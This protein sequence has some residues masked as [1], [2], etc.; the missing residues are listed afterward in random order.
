MLLAA[1]NLLW[2]PWTLALSIALWLATAVVGWMS[3][4]RSGYRRQIA[5]L[6]GI[7]LSVLA[8]VALLINQPEFLQIQKRQGKPTVAVLVDRSASMETADIP[9]GEENPSELVRRSAMA[10]PL[11]SEATWS[12]LRQRFDVALQPICSAQPGSGSNLCGPLENLVENSRDLVAIVLVSDGD[13]NEGSAPINAANRLRMANI[14][15]LS[16]PVGSPL[17]LP[18]VELKS[19]N[20]PAIG[21]V[22]K[23]LRIPFT[24][25]SSLP[26]DFVAAVTLTTST[27]E[28]VAADVHVE[29]NSQTEGALV[30]RPVA[31][32]RYQITVKVPVESDE[33]VVD[34]NEASASIDV[35]EELIKVLVIEDHPRWEYR[36]LRN[37]L[38][39]DE[40]V[41]VSCLL[42]QTGMGKVGGG[43]KEYIKS[44]PA[45]REELA[46]YDVVFLGD[47][48]VNESQ[49]TA[50]QCELLAGLVQQQ[51]SGL[52]FMPG[53]Q[54]NQASLLQ[55]KLG[56]LYPVVLDD[57]EPYGL[58]SPAVNQLEL[59]ES[60]EKSLL[61]RLGPSEDS[62][63]SIWEALP[64]FNWCAA[65]SRAKV[66]AE[67]LGVHQSMENEFGRLPLLVSN[68]Y[69]V[70]KV[71]FMGTDSAW[72]W[73]LGF[74][75]KFH[76]RFWAQV[77]RWM[78]YQRNMAKGSSM[79]FFFSP[80][81]PAARQTIAMQANVVGPDG[82]P[83]NSGDVI[84]EIKAPSGQTAAVRLQAA[85]DDWGAYD[86]TWQPAEAGEHKVLVKCRQTGDTL[87]SAIYVRSAPLEVVGRPARPEVLEEI[88]QITGGKVLRPNQIADVVNYV[89][90][91]PEPPPTQRRVQIWSHPLT[92][93]VLVS[94]LTVF[95]V[96]RKSAGLI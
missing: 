38:S 94:A 96:A 46:E 15:V 11:L 13:W 62:S 49:L 47:V 72:K 90:E 59:T 80:D 67:V 33:L 28:E 86:G 4:R 63:R 50:E 85:G 71:L 34:N 17:R 18:D 55:T 75:D 77:V 23:D 81:A 92:I 51:A 79:R 12:S 24:I 76:Y 41:E 68:T 16:I 64:G 1:F 9:G 29:A 3:W 60:G 65:V 53:P 61:T 73:R 5:V 14:P 20:S 7:R 10:N 43:N 36:F 78:A 6:E 52:V 32:G 31:A 56:D 91:L 2:T 21:I 22:N 69:G 70:G 37:A 25:D 87:E 66:G 19:V 58:G 82:A 45:T 54:G 84:V 26:R 44:F 30:W 27:G 35:R 42:F 57:A 74:E 39:R 88:A 8:L 48:G 93:V 95:W 40:G 83:L 89:S